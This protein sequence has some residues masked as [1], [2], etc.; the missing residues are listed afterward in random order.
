ME[1]NFNYFN[2]QIYPYGYYQNVP[3]YYPTKPVLKKSSS[4][5]NIFHNNNDNYNYGNNYL[6]SNL[7]YNYGNNYLP[8]NLNYNYGNNYS[9]SNLNY[10]YGNK[11]L[12][13]SND[14]LPSIKNYNYG[15][16]N[17][18]NHP[19][20][21]GLLEKKYFYKKVD[22]KIYNLSNM[23]SK[24][25]FIYDFISNNHKKKY[26]FLNMNNIKNN[27]HDK[28]IYKT[29]N[30]NNIKNLSNKNLEVLKP[31]KNF[32]SVPK[33]PLENKKTL[34]MKLK[35]ENK[36]FINNSL[37]HKKEDI[38][39][40]KNKLSSLIQEKN[41]I[42]S[43]PKKDYIN[44]NNEKNK[45]S[46]LSTILDFCN[47]NKTN[48]I[49]LEKLKSDYK[50]N[51]YE[52]KDI[53]VDIASLVKEIKIN[54]LKINLIFFYEDFSDENVD[55][56]NKLK[57]NI[58][59]GYF[60][61]RKVDIFEKLL[62]EMKIDKSGSSFILIC[63][64]SSFEKI[65]K[66]CNEFDCI[67]YIIIFCMNVNHYKKKYESNL[68][69]KLISKDQKEIY[70]YLIEISNNEPN[71]NKK[72][73]NLIN[74]NLLI[75]FYEY[76]N[77]YYIHHKMLSFFFKEDFSKLDFCDDYMEKVFNFIDED[78]DL[79]NKEKKE[80]KQIIENLKNSLDFLNDILKFYTSESKY[81]YLFNRTMRNIEVGMERLS[82]L[83][84]PMYYTIVRYL[85][86]KDSNL[87]FN[88]RNK[89]FRNIYINQYDLENYYM[90]KGKI[91]CFPSF[92]STSFKKGFE[93][94]NKALNVNNLYNEKILLKMELSY[95]PE[96]DNIPQ[97][98]ILKD[99]SVNPSEE[100]I[101]LFPFTFI[102]VKSIKKKK[103]NF[104]ELKGKIINKDSILEFGL[105]KGK[106]V[107]LKNE[108]LTIE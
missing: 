3:L 79:K 97:G 86:K 28:Q 49:N 81:V 45:I 56:Y 5:P 108:V 33:K 9:P 20:K 29:N 34:Y 67:K 54:K 80:L 87:M 16:D 70:D 82:F 21:Y 47:P 18:N 99:F 19:K 4:G 43:S 31:K 76:E 69:V 12:A 68:K 36:I 15:N 73:K 102:K 13:P 37:N 41:S 30:I 66:I 59:G 90:A 103:N 11:Y 10:N 107:F 95:K 71:Y 63:I 17:E 46:F 26:N 93:P 2:N 32:V 51:S 104:Y 53:K 39:Y 35:I 96:Y 6:P 50:E 74:H 38:S 57:L 83:I 64:G 7:N 94:T 77:Y 40:N 62:N 61:V 101:L 25:N 8:S 88:E 84:G 72:L 100:E 92:T 98:M 14:F 85:M 105:R 106:K 22:P 1:Y 78:T 48:L 60:G 24:N 91:I 89:L 58:L 42:L 27:Q 55:L 44:K 23:K 52:A 65:D 75:S